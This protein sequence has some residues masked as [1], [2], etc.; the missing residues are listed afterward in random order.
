MSVSITPNY[1]ELVFDGFRVP[2][3]VFDFDKFHEWIHADGFPE[4]VHVCYIDGYV[5]IDMNPEVIES[6]A[7]FNGDVFGELHDRQLQQRLSEIVMPLAGELVFN[8]FRVP[9]EVFDFEK[10]LD[11]VHRDDFPEGVRVTY[12]DGRIEIEMSPEEIETHNKLKS[13]VHACLWHWNAERQIGEIHEDGVL[14]INSDANM[15][16][17]PN[18][19]FCSWADTQSGRGRF[20]ERI[21]GSNRLI[22]VVGSPDLVVE[23]V[24]Q[25]SVRKDAVLLRK[26]YFLAGVQEYCLIDGRGE[27]IDFQLLARGELEFESVAAD[28]DGYRRP[29]V[30]GGGFLL[31]RSLNRAG[32]FEYRLTGREDDRPARESVPD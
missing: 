1:G 32:R 26:Q 2:A 20:A 19:M 24:S 31:T 15:S 11:W 18:V 3:G 28:A 21:E 30:L 4:K 27:T 10:F 13:A 7:S 22:D 17:E 12:I 6:N 29:E 9:A 25:S 14:L 16:G 8:E 23:V 5:Q